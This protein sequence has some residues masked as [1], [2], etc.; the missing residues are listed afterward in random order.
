MYEITCPPG[1][2]ATLWSAGPLLGAVPCIA[3]ADA[4]RDLAVSRA[5][6]STD[7]YF[8]L[9]WALVE[10]I[11]TPSLPERENEN[12]TR[13]HPRSEHD[14]GSLVLLRAFGGPSCLSTR[15]HLVD[16]ADPT[17]TLHRVSPLGAWTAHGYHLNTGCPLGP[18][19]MAVSLPRRPRRGPGPE[20]C[21]HEH[22]LQFRRVR[23]IDGYAAPQNA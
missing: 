5:L 19:F 17:C 15:R 4:D 8:R 22:S 3:L 10:T 9:S 6:Q 20:Y 16:H 7:G 18:R 1:T 12:A 2:G 23:L 13:W 21:F 11:R 14:P